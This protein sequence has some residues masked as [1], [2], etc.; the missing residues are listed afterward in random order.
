MH[1]IGNN[2][3]RY[4]RIEVLLNSCHGD[5]ILGVHAIGGPADARRGDLGDDALHHSRVRG[6]PTVGAEEGVQ[7]F[8][9]RDL[10]VD[11]DAA[12]ADC[13]GCGTHQ[14]ADLADGFAIRS[15]LVRAPGRIALLVEGIF[16]ILPAN[17]VGDLAVSV[18]GLVEVGVVDL[19]GEGAISGGGGASQ[20][21]EVSLVADV[22]NVD[23]GI[24]GDVGHDLGVWRLLGLT[25]V[26]DLVGEGHDGGEVQV[27]AVTREA[28]VSVVGE[29]VS[30]K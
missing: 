8:R 2:N 16:H 17:D 23:D 14:A 26:L 28:V 10:T 25:N 15:H 30:I 6:V 7:S 11:G 12:A 4:I 24:G 18:D 27:V 29:E 13:H 9:V 1:D 20:E 19:E 5:I 3:T 22:G 21:D